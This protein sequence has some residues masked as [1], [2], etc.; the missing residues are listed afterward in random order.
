MDFAGKPVEPNVLGQIAG[1]DEVEARG[2]KRQR[3]GGGLHAWRPPE[4]AVLHEQHRPVGV[5]TYD[6]SVTEATP[7]SVED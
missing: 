2:A 5:E 6:R 4:P 3:L 7:Q 1:G